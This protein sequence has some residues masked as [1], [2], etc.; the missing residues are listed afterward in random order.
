M[1]F[2]GLF[3]RWG[4]R[5]FSVFFF[6]LGCFLFAGEDSRSEI[7][8]DVGDCDGEKHQIDRFDDAGERRTRDE[9]RKR[10]DGSS[11]LDEN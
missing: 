3:I 4:G 9:K 11:S 5:F 8:E 1:P 7:A 10:P 6:R 2:T